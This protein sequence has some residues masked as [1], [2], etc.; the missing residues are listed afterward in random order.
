MVYT[1]QLS[2]CPVAEK[3]QMVVQ[4]ATPRL[5]SDNRSVPVTHN[6]PPAV[7]LGVQVPWVLLR[8]YRCLEWVESGRA[9]C[10]S[11][12]VVLRV[13]EREVVDLT[14][15]EQSPLVLAAVVKEDEVRV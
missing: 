6:P 12:V 3:P 2:T 14:D 1:V 10:S 5:L 11:L 13:Q 9:G 8:G 15:D 4:L 7:L